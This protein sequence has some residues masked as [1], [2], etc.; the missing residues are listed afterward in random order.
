MSKKIE[1]PVDR[2]PG[3]VI[4]SDPL[5]YPQVFAFE[6][7]IKAANEQRE[8]DPENFGRM[9]YC[10]LPGILPCVEEWHIKGIP[11]HPTQ[12]TF[13]ATPR[14]A[15]ANL[16]GWLVGELTVLQVEAEVVPN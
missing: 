11:E 8:K 9:F 10:W 13:P 15:A 14:L 3:H 5:T 1:S 16:M 12:D 7:A 2:F 6:D 4:L